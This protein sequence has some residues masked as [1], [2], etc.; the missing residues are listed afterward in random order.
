[1]WICIVLKC[2]HLYLIFLECEFSFQNYLYLIIQ[3]NLSVFFI[4][5]M[6]VFFTVMSFIKNL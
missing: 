5:I 3:I 1:M 6:F 2:K 4:G